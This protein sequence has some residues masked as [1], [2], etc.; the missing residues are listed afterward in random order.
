MAALPSPRDGRKPRLE[1]I[2]FIDIM[3][4]LLATFMM[5]SLSMIDNQGVEL[6]LPGAASAKAQ[7]QIDHA[8]TVSV[9]KT[10]ELFLNKEPITLP[11][12]QEKFSQLLAEK[13]E[14][15]LVLQGDYDCPYGRVVEV[16]DSARM[17]GMTKSVIRTVRPK[18][19]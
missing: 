6:N 18:R 2:P 10:G 15:R 17:R 14:T 8:Q 4:F 13:P 7:D 19:Q 9:A 16:F 1:I 11:T 5:V 12:L 3:F